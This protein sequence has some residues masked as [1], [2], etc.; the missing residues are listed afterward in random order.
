LSVTAF[1]IGSAVS[2]VVAGRLVERFGRRLTVLGLSLVTVGI[3]AAALVLLLVPGDIAGFCVAPA[4]LV[5]GI[6]GG[7]TISPNITMTLSNVP[8][9]MAGSAGGALQT[10]QR[11]G[12][13]I[14]TALSAGVFYGVL[15]A[16][17]G[18]FPAAIAASLGVAV[19]TT[20]VAL[21]VAVVDLRHEGRRTPAGPVEP[22]APHHLPVD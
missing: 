21:G 15:A 18:S 10:G 11:V 6:G 14:G 5:G 4:L 12:A 9:R 1:A 8:V 22:G 20:L 16:S 17:G 3:V 13:A 19:L 2:A 7:F